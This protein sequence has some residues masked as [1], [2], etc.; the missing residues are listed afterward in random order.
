MKTVEKKNLVPKC[1]KKKK[2]HKLFLSFN[3]QE[4]IGVPFDRNFNSILRRDHQ[5]ISYM[6]LLTMSR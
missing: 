2:K 4:N 3:A 1:Q 6:S 5:K